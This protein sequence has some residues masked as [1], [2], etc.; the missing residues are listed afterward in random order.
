MPYF[1]DGSLSR[2]QLLR[3]LSFSPVPTGIYA[4]DDVTI[5]A[6]NEAM[7]KVWGKN[8][9]VIGKQM[10]DALPELRNQP[11]IDI[12]RECI[13]TGTDY[14]A[15]DMPVHLEVDGKLQLYYFD[16]VY[17]AVAM[18]DGS[19]IILNTAKDITDRFETMVTIEELNKNL[20][21]ANQQYE[22][23]NK[24][25]AA[26][27]E[28]TE[29]QRK[30]LHDFI[31]EA[32]EGIC[33]LTGQDLVFEFLNPAYQKLLPNRQLQGM[34]LFEALPELKGQPIET[35]LRDL[36]VTGETVSMTETPVVL[37]NARTGVSEQRYF[38]FTYQPRKNA[39]GEV[40]GVLVFVYEVT[41]HVQAR[42]QVEESEKHFRHLADMLPVKVS[43]GTPQGEVT[44][45]N[46]QWLDFAG[47]SFEEL[48]SFG[49]H[50]M[51]HPDEIEAYMEK[52]KAGNLTKS[53][54]VTELRFRN[55]EGKYI[56]HLAESSPLLDE[57]GEVRMWV[58]STI[59]IQHFKEEEQRKSDFVN[60]FSHEL[61]TPLTSIKGY[62]QFLLMQL[63]S[64]QGGTI[65]REF[66]ES[67]LSRVNKLVRQ[68][69]GLIEEMLDFGRIEKGRLGIIKTS[70][71]LNALVH[72]VVGDTSFINPQYQIRINE[73]DYC[74]VEADADKLG[75]VLTN[76][77]S[78]AIKY[79]P[80]SR[81]IDIRIFKKDDKY[82]AVS[83]K[84]YGI[85]IDKKEHSKVF[86]RFYRVEGKVESKIAGFGIGLFI[87]HSIVLE[88][89]G[90][91]EIVSEKGK[92][93]EFT[94]F[95]PLTTENS[96]T[97][98]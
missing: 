87:A 1:N 42:K 30:T 26:S 66:L 46:K 74:T 63:Q 89:N 24:E 6:A 32:P 81:K 59:D 68:L 60:M 11:F 58:A 78:N 23:T 10:Y 53:P 93:A 83:V 41:D 61:K 36:L 67:S 34:P 8:E 73:D 45:F 20:V 37:E 47:M 72:S 94:F 28:E 27:R 44:F 77:I 88:H 38:T 19:Y 69:T 96:G 62:V 97:P 49:Y 70:T 5:V 17:K 75:Q 79:A 55:K 50:K 51:M 76:F 3:I 33:V 29:L 22:L 90:Y 31:M 52:V 9:S 7:L 16:F 56:W 65:S 4:G 86:D 64:E 91:I 12:L 39:G 21:N 35:M 98:Q 14:E 80:E 43:N 57:E 92:G 40:L 15:R 95:I 2:D 18:E 48:K 82:A 13:R 25:L 54:R 85:G 84:D 71:D